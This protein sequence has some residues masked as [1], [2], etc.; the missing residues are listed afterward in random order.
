M[1]FSALEA[2]QAFGAGRQMA[3]QDRQVRTRQQVGQMA[4]T[5]DYTG[6]ANTALQGGDYELAGQVR[7]LSAQ[8]RQQALQEASLLEGEATG[9]AAI[10]DPAARQ[11]AWV[12]RRPQIEALGFFGPHELDSVD[13]SDAGL[14]G[15]IQHGRT[16]RQLLQP[17]G[18]Q[19]QP[20]TLQRNDQYIR[21][22]Y[23]DAAGDAYVG[24]QVAPPPIV[25]HNADGTITITPQAA[26]I[27]R[28]RDAQPA[29]Q[30]PVTR[31]PDQLRADAEEA[32]RKGADPA[33][34]NAR[35]QQ[36]LG[37]SAD[38]RPQSDP[39]PAFHPDPNLPTFRGVQFGNPLRPGG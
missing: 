16:A 33:A 20:T 27:L 13:L 32:I 18:Q 9:L 25:Q 7:Q 15:Y 38:A 23:G 30:Q 34:V 28:R 11:A 19:Q 36:M 21:D 8:Q 39:A 24:R 29:Q 2:L 6:A 31:T 4:S 35:L 5:G 17:R 3:L 10:T 26:P 37:G 1:A 22:T 14:Q 12:A